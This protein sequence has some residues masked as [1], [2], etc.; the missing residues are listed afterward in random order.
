MSA[1]TDRILR[2]FPT[3]LA[4]FWIACDPDDVLLDEGVLLGSHA[5]V[6]PGV[7]VGAYAVVGAGSIVLRKVRPGSTVFGSPA[8][9]VPGFAG[10]GA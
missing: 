8:R 4:R 1:W 3:E 5:V 10:T 2:E 6:L 9:Q 7:T